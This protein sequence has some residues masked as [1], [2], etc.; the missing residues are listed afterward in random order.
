MWKAALAMVIPSTV[1]LSTLLMLT[2]LYFQ[3]SDSSIGGSTDFGWGIKSPDNVPWP[4]I[5]ESDFFWKCLDFPII[6]MLYLV[7]L[8]TGYDHLILEPSSL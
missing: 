1:T 5:L 2:D 6:E 4:K 8:I 7:I 3:Y